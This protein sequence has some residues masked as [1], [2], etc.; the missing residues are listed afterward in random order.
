MGRWLTAALLPI[1]FAKPQNPL[2]GVF[3]SD[4][5]EQSSFWSTFQ[6]DFDSEASGGL[7]YTE[8]SNESNQAETEVTNQVSLLK[9]NT[10]RHYQPPPRPNYEVAN[11]NDFHYEMNPLTN[12]T[13]EVKERHPI[14]VELIEAGQQIFSEFPLTIDYEDITNHGCWCSKFGLGFGAG[15]DPIDALDEICRQWFYARRCVMLPGGRC[16][17]GFTAETYEIKYEN[18]IQ[19][20]CQDSSKPGMQCLYHLC[21]IDA[22][23][24]WSIY[25]MFKERETNGLEIV[26]DAT[27]NPISVQQHD[28][29]CIGYYP[30]RLTAIK[31]PDTSSCAADEEKQPKKLCGAFVAR[32]LSNKVIK[33]NKHLD[34]ND[35]LWV[36]E[37]AG[38]IPSEKGVLDEM[39]LAGNVRGFIERP[40]CKMTLFERDDCM[41][42]PFT[43]RD[44]T[45]YFTLAN[46]NNL[47]ARVGASF[48][49]KAQRYECTCADDVE[50]IDGTNYTGF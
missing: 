45:S 15:G 7:E 14:P 2:D 30:D 31:K 23:F 9:E 13:I 20:R 5:Q 25:Q 24:S 6:D 1:G 8:Q 34:D 33:R 47:C 46:G 36:G 3:N 17:N 49:K 42:F 48:E 50:I 28:K 16:E 27:C 11:K 22:H 29:I 21:V 40:G 26:R 4:D 41:G 19:K 44:C 12:K 35:I 32:G 38:A 37:G 18:K 43:I 39:V 10:Y